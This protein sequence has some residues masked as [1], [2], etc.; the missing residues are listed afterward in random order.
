MSELFC[1]RIV[2]DMINY[3]KAMINDGLNINNQ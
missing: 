3:S 2:T 1:F